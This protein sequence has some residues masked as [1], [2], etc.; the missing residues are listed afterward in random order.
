MMAEI[1]GQT[2]NAG[3]VTTAHLGGRFAHF[4]VE[5]GVFFDDQ[6]SRFRSL[7][8]QNKRGCRAGKCATNDYDIVFE[9]H[10][11]KTMDFAGSKRNP[12]RLALNAERGTSSIERN[13]SYQRAF[14]LSQWHS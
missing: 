4:A 12:L 6:D 2:Q 1:M 14:D 5:L 3:H 13:D 11:L 7:P 9:I 8:L 10:C